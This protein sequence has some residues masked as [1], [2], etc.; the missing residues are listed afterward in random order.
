[1]PRPARFRPARLRPGPNTLTCRCEV[2]R[3]RRSRA[4]YLISRRVDLARPLLLDGIP[5]RD[6]AAATGFHD[7][8]HLIRHFKRILG[9]TPGQYARSAHGLHTRTNLPHQ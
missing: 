9:T 8:P 1:M 5:A 3:R 4:G 6:V 7:Q 2:A